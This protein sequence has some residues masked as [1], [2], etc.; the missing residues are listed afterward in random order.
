M[1]V[2][3]VIFALSS[4]LSSATTSVLQRRAVGEA[5]RSGGRGLRAAAARLLQPLK[6]PIW[7]A[8]AAAIGSGALFQTLALD[9]GQLAVVQPLL[10]SELLFTLVIGT[11]V[12]HHRPGLA[13]W[14]A[15]AMLAA[16]LAIFLGSASPADGFGRPSGWRWSIA[17]VGVLGGVAGLLLVARFVVGSLRA[18]VLGAATAV[19]FAST[20]ALIKETTQRFHSGLEGVVTSWP[21]YAAAAAGASS[22]LLLQRTLRAGTLTASQPA[23]TL[24]DALISVLLGAALFG[25][26][27]AVGWRIVLE[28]AGACLIACG[29]FGLTRTPAASEEKSWD[30]AAPSRR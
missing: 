17:G 12:F 27:V 24:G 1:N 5:D 3:T 23:L 19:G 14:L 25:E 30:A 13:T 15:F 6:R 7:W 10:S 20:A 9:T 21:V 11:V 4:G 26:R 8:G 18:A 2:L 16:G 28:A 22:M 29:V